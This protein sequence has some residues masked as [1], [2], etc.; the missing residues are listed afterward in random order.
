MAVSQG[1]PSQPS[2]DDATNPPVP[3]EDI[4][5]ELSKI[6]SPAASYLVCVGN[7]KPGNYG[8]GQVQRFSHHQPDTTI[9]RE[10]K[11]KEL[12]D[13]FANRPGLYQL[14]SLAECEESQALNKDQTPQ[15]FMS[16]HGW[17]MKTSQPTKK[18][19]G[20]RTKDQA[21]QRQ[22]PTLNP[23]RRSGNHSGRVLCRH[24]HRR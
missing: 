9:D 17:F 10:C 3:I 22:L 4:V 13:F 6:L 16:Y 20:K 1:G 8:E 7:T 12:M 2:P 21:R 23:S 11:Y 18:K 24:R 5:S 14:R 15:H 19:K